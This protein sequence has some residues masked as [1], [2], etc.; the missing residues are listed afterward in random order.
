MIIDHKN[1]FI[2]IAVPKTASSSVHFLLNY[3]Q[4]QKPKLHHMG[5]ADVI[6]KHPETA[7]YFK[8]SFSRNPYS[9]LVSVYYDLKLNPSH[10]RWAHPI[11]K[12]KNFKDFCLRL[13]DGE[14]MNF[15][16]IKRQYD[17]VECD[18]EIGVDF[19]GK[20]ENLQHD[21]LEIE[22]RMVAM[23]RNLLGK[24][25]CLCA[26][27]GWSL[28]D[29]KSHNTFGRR[30]KRGMFKTITETAKSGP[31]LLNQL[32]LDAKFLLPH[33][34]NRTRWAKGK[35]KNNW[36][37]EYDRASRAAVYKIYQKDFESFGYEK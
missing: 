23:G 18:G 16:H 15:M 22:N 26:G 35:V 30:P 11:L 8:F 10:S 31:L 34:R 21:L 24:K 1:K 20:F 5:L 4:H 13:S 36:A 2:F 33:R 12:Y 14:C 6:K 32:L 9:R 27:P 29:G 25:C 17:C 3:R 37:K 28:F 19:C 7:S